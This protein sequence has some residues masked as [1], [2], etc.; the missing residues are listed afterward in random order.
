MNPA[1]REGGSARAEC[2]ASRV[3]RG[4]GEGQ[5]GIV[6]GE[7]DRMGEVGWAGCAGYAGYA[8]CAGDEGRGG[9]VA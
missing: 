5:W 3:L 2:G 7:G 4:K 9:D 1:A 6:M 8:G